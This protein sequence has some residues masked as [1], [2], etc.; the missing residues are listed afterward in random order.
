MTP[1]NSWGTRR[2]TIGHAPRSDASG[3]Y[4]WCVARPTE[5]RTA[6][7]NQAPKISDLVPGKRLQQIET[8][9]PI[10]GWC[11]VHPR[12][13][14]RF[15]D[16]VPWEEDQPVVPDGFARLAS[17][18]K[19][20]QLLDESVRL[21]ES[22]VSLREQ[23]LLANQELDAMSKKRDAMVA[24]IR[25][26]REEQTL[27]QEKLEECRQHR[28]WMKEK[29][30]RCSEVVAFTVST[31]DHLHEVAEE[32]DGSSELVKA[33]AMVVAAGTAAKQTLEELEE[34]ENEEEA[35]SCEFSN[36]NP[37]YDALATKEAKELEDVVLPVVQQRSPLQPRNES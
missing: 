22:N 9:R 28:A 32:E 27:E 35:P 14:V 17:L 20:M 13:F 1:E 7:S 15:D 37:C 34:E 11:P 24:E 25:Q 23:G 8:P 3:S 19:H 26:L 5:W 18:H 36:E 12:G 21:R 31:I 10:A 16:L 29:L 6:P 33:Q 4:E 2:C 30:H